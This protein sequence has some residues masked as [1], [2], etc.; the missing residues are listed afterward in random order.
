MLNN[1][2]K[3]TLSMKTTQ[4]AIQEVLA[5]RTLALVGVSR[6]GKKFG[7][8]I[9]RDLKSK[10]YKIFPVHP[11]AESIEG[12]PC[13][14]D[15]KSLPEKAGAVV[16]C[17]PPAEA[18][19]VVQQAFEAGIT[20]VWLQQGAESYAAIQYCENHEMAIVHG[21]CIMMFGEPVR[22]YHGFHRWIWRLIG[23]YPAVSPHHTS[24][25]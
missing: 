22:S 5:Q 17:I 12:E 9:Y 16:I 20:R 25:L 21:Q 24:S 3:E 18:E 13:Y 6:G 4:N 8:V 10:G 7:N 23:K 15:L 14:P 19:R 11:K 2:Q 1:G